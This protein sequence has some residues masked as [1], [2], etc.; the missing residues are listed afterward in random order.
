MLLS[1]NTLLPFLCFAFVASITPGPTN[2]LVLSHS[3]RYGFKAVL[4]IIFGASISA[5]S[6]V[7][8]VG[9]GFGESLNQ[10]A[11][12]PAVMK[13]LGVI[14]LS[15]LAWQIFHSPPHSFNQLSLDSPRRAGFWA[16]ACLQWIN[17]KTWMM[18]MAVVGVFST[19]GEDHLLHVM[20]L[21]LGFL[22]VA[23]PCLGVWGGLGVGSA[24]LI[25]SDRAQINFN[26]FMGF[27]LLASTWAGALITEAPST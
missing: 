24:R 13:G 5:A 17:P 8:L 21:S 25:G 20:C 1:L 12:L 2:I 4:P 3:A 26:R 11:L 6:M 7:L 18:A 15:Y 10:Y 23:L 14:G 22:L 19:T 16:A 9:C 27:L